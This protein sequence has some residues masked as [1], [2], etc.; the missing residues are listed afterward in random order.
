MT[1]LFGSITL[2]YTTAFTFAGTLSLV[3][4][5]WVGT[6]MVT[7]LRSILTILSIMGMRKK[8]PG[9]LALPCTLPSLK[10]TPRSYSLT[11]LIALIMTEPTKI[12]IIASTMNAKPISTACNNPRGAYTRY[13]PLSLALRIQ[14]PAVVRP[15]HRHHLHHSS[16]TE[17]HHNHFAPRSYYCLGI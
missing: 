8:S 11:I 5:S 7:V 12:T 3:I 10:I 9:P 2:K 4:S 6:S 15:L 17:P 16:V 13:P 14:R 1:A